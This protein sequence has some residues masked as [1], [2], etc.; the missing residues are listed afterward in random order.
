MPTLRV[1]GIPAHLI[2]E[3]WQ[4]REYDL[5]SRDQRIA[6]CKANAQQIFNWLS[7]NLPDATKN[8]LKLLIQSDL[9]F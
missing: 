2:V 5:L 6:I 8:E 4:P 1:K 7:R 3:N 9:H